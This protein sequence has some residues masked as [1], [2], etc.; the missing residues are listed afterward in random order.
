MINILSKPADQIAL[1][2]IEQLIS[3]EVPEGDHLEFKE[4]LPAEGTS[5][6]PWIEGKNHIGNPAKDKLLKECVAFANAHGGVLLLG[7]KESVSS[8]PVA[9]EIL[10]LPRPVDLADRL[11]LVFR[12][13]VEPQLPLL[14]ILP[15]LTDGDR[16]IILIRV[17]P[18]AAG[19]PSGGKNLSMPSSEV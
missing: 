1:V 7:I 12:D 13:R 16:G 3:S 6:D 14:E 19:P 5:I 15:I 10:P 17:G 11:K 8:P 18:F 2:D 9:T 4:T